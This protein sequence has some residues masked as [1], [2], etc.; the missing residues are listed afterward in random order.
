[1]R[2]AFTEA[3]SAALIHAD[4]EARRL[5]QEFVGAEHLFL[6]LLAADCDALRSLKSQASPAELRKILRGLLPRNAHPELVT[7]RLPLS[8]KATKIVNLAI[9]EACGANIS[10]VST[11]WLLH[12][13][14]IRNVRAVAQ[15]LSQAGAD[16]DQL[17]RVLL[18]SEK[19]AE[20]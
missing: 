6:G 3:L 11:R 14:L 13:I 20:A 17:S 15:A 8:P 19:S 1:M 12:A 16:A 4:E 9:S 18:Q 7:G 10:L 2:H 5:G